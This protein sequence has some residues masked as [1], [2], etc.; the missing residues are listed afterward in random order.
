MFIISILRKCKLK[1]YIFF[2]HKPIKTSE[3]S[4]IDSKI[5]LL[6]DENLNWPSPLRMQFGNKKN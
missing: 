2:T 5:I 6:A 4:N 3:L 1:Q